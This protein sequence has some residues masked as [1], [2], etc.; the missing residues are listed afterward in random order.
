MDSQPFKPATFT[1]KLASSTFNYLA[2]LAHIAHMT[3][4]EK[5][6]DAAHRLAGAV[7]NDH[8]GRL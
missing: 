2:G 7:E 5:D 4:W 3:H 6:A 8:E 1:S